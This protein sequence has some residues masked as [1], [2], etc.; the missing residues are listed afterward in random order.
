MKF[1][2][3]FN[4]KSE[5][6]K[7][8]AGY[9]AFD[10]IYATEPPETT[11]TRGYR[12][13]L[14]GK[15]YQLLGK[16]NYISLNNQDIRTILNLYIEKG[17]DAFNLVDGDYTCIIT[18]KGD[19]KIIRDFKGTGPQ[20]FY[21]NYLFS[22]S[23]KTITSLTKESL[24]PDVET[25]SL[26]LKYG[27]V[28]PEAS[29]IEGIKRLKAGNILLNSHNT[30]RTEPYT[31]PGIIYSKSVMDMSEDELSDIY[32]NLHTESIKH[33]IAGKE[34]IGLLL[35]GGYDSG[36][37]LAGLRSI[38]SGD[39]NSYTIS[40]KNNPHSE[41]EF[42]K[43][44][45]KE[46]NAS[47]KHYEI[48]GSE[49]SF[50]P[51][52][53][54]SIGCPFQESGLMINYLV[55]KMA[56]KDKPDVILGGD[57]N[58][59]LFGTASK[60]I[61]L[62]TLTNMTG[63]FVCQS[64]LKG[65]IGNKENSNLFK[66]INF[67]NDKIYKIVNP[68][69][70]GF[71]NA[72]LNY[73]TQEKNIFNTGRTFS[74]SFR[75]LYETH[76]KK[77]DIPFTATNVIL[78]KAARMA[79]LFDTPLTYPYFSRSVY[80]FVNSLPTGLKIKGSFNDQLKGRSISKYMHKKTY[81]H[82]L[83]KSITHRKK[84]GGFVPL[85]M[86]FQDEWK[87]DKLFKLIKSSLLLK[88]LLKNSDGLINDLKSAISDKNT[89]FWYQQVYYSRVFNLLVLAVWEKLFLEGKSPETIKFISNEN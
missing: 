58:D 48:N 84:Q 27:F 3:F 41:L 71:N 73:K 6:Y 39:I 67:Y 80:D 20:V 65:I 35:S 78:Y 31:E 22:N 32:F 81:G 8:P 85:S 38:Y 87:N 7:I 47:L 43:I 79:E 5:G 54:E 11:K 25:L 1:F 69:H 34:K 10:G 64:L 19:T 15:V 51:E 36:G 28:A 76:R 26:F 29:G 16:E 89:W 61:A 49:I 83:P 60:E 82:R 45:S 68:D 14:W 86:F 13:F 9:T 56:A 18:Y 59:Q 40:F 53:V 33:R 37:N 42:V 2:G 63:L 70:W 72:H 44:L 21:T 52:L 23:F 30:V 12:L 88:S 4:N 57:G 46:F 55:M 74:V 62:K 24:D 50:L 75:E 66:K 17:S 77:I